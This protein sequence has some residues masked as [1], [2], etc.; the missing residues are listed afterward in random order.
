[1]NGSWRLNFRYNR[2]KQTLVIQKE[3]W[4]SKSK[5]RVSLKSEEQKKSC[6]SKQNYPWHIKYLRN[7]QSAPAIHRLKRMNEEGQEVHCLGSF[8]PHFIFT[9]PAVFQLH[10]F[11]GCR[12]TILTLSPEHCHAL[13][14]NKPQFHVLF[15]AH[16]D[17]PLGRSNWRL[18]DE[19]LFLQAMGYISA[20]PHI[21][22]QVK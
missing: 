8:S 6:I 3:G 14:I 19:E 12:G 22:S 18:P 20:Q 1:M 17:T 5:T 7:I 21:K 10:I 11:F 16:R 13:S 4:K 9:L 15:T 2:L